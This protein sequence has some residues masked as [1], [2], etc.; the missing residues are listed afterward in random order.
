MHDPAGGFIQHARLI[1][2]L[3]GSPVDVLVRED[4]KVT[5]APIVAT[6]LQDLGFDA[7]VAR[8]HEV[9]IA[10]DECCSSEATRAGSRG[11]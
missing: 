5:R 11:C 7:R 2:T 6:I 10:Q 1:E 9:E 3:H 8:E 4:I